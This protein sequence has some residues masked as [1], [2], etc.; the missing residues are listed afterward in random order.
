MRSSLST[1]SSGFAFALSLAFGLALGACGDPLQSPVTLTVGNAS[2]GD[3][4]SDAP[5]AG[6]AFAP[7]TGVDPCSSGANS[8]TGDFKRLINT[9]NGQ[10]YYLLHV[11]KSY[12]AAPTELVLNFHGFLSNP[13]QEEL[14][15]GMNAAADSRNILVAYPAG[16]HNS[17]DAGACCGWSLANKIDDVGFTSAVIDDIASQYCVDQKRVFATGMSNGAFMT[18]RL[19]CELSNRIAA[20]AP[21]AG[22]IGVPTCAPPRP[23]PNMHFH[24][25]RDPLVPYNGS[26]LFGFE[27]VPASYATWTQVDGCTG[28]E[29]TIFSNGDSTC[30]EHTGC[31]AGSEAILCT[32]SDGGHTWPGGLPIPFLGITTKDM[33]ATQMMLDFFERHPMP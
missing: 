14:L 1:S 26:K 10:R 20:A 2:T 31:A 16:L 8:P 30:V 13:S 18:H 17:W 23:V 3:E 27:S 12:T 19:A 29:E 33:S 15:T 7:N 11:P 4:A 24:G 25:E 6:A 32:V 28:P 22:V 21:V 9:A 5:P